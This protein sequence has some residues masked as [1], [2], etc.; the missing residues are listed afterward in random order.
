[1]FKWLGNYFTFSN[2]ERNGI[3]VLL[4]LAFL[5]LLAPRLYFIFKPVKPVTDTTFQSD[6]QAF[7]K[8]QQVSNIPVGAEDFD[9]TLAVPAVINT[10]KHYDNTSVAVLNINTA[11]SAQL[12]ALP[13]IGP[14]LARRILNFRR[15][16]GGYAS[17]EQIRE[18]WGMPDSTYR[19]LKPRLR[20]DGKVLKI[21]LN[22][23]DAGTL[24][25]HPYLSSAQGK[26][27][28]AYRQKNGNFTSPEQLKSIPVL[29]DSTL[30]KMEP[31]F[32]V[33]TQ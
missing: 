6:V 7:L 8:Q 22:E 10:S 15:A 32:T 29:P 31:Y 25:K 18:V 1:M 9:D 3:M 20:C 5:A 26:A 28:I 13:G 27:I 23:A 21:N 14:V 33:K 17:V 12:E 19:T 11:D 16:L 4:L 2:W 30:R 24:A